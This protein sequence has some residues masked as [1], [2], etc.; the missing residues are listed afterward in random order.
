[1]ERRCSA[2]A[3]VRAAKKVEASAHH[4]IVHFYRQW[5][6]LNG[7]NHESSYENRNKQYI[8]FNLLP[9]FFAHKD[10]AIVKAS[11]VIRM[12]LKKRRRMYDLN[13]YSEKYFDTIKAI[14]KRFL[15][16]F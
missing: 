4:T 13:I 3:A 8:S 14:E 9:I 1:L 12:Y 2:I 11:K 15:E 6:L 7:Q 10:Q 16:K 5:F